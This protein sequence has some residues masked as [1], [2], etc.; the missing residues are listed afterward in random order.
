MKEWRR[1]MVTIKSK[2]FLE[3]MVEGATLGI[4]FVEFSPPA[5]D[6]KSS[7]TAPKQKHS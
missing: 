3:F 2:V 4:H 7:F 6:D 5:S 1:L